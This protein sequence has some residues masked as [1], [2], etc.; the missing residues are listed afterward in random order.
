[1]FEDL[2]ALAADRLGA[3]GRKLIASVRLVERSAGNPDPAQSVNAL[4]K[5]AFTWDAADDY[6][7]MR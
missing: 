2:A 3:D 7:G 4:E 1:V 6:M 5:L